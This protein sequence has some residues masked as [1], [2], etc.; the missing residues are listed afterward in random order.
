MWQFVHSYMSL[1]PAILT[2]ALWEHVFWVTTPDVNCSSGL[3]MTIAVA[4]FLTMY[5]L[6]VWTYFL[7]VWLHCIHD[8]NT[9]FIL[10]NP[11]SMKHYR[12]RWR[13]VS[14]V[15]VWVCISARKDWI[16]YSATCCCIVSYSLQLIWF[17]QQYDQKSFYYTI[18]PLSFFSNTWPTQCFVGHAIFWDKLDVTVCT[19]IK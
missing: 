10:I 2:F 18:I 6:A 5:S 4:S 1:S 19:R 14:D 13:N 7:T 12:Q 15:V 16:D 9:P 11:T 17:W 8:V 3:P